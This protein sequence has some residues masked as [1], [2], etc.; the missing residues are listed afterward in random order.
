MTDDIVVRLRLSTVADSAQSIYE[1]M[2]QAADEIERLRKQIQHAHAI[3][4]SEAVGWLMSGANHPDAWRE[5]LDEP[6]LSYWK[7]YG[8]YFKPKNK[9]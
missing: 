8:S 6:I 1:T 3:L 4:S 5:D 2:T 9:P 7:E